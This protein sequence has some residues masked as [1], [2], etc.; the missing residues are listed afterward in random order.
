[1]CINVV[2]SQLLKISNH[3]LFFSLTFNKRIIGIQ[4]VLHIFKLLVTTAASTLLIKTSF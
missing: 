4:N 2:T 1:M 3:L